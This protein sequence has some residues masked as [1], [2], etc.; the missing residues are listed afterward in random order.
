MTIKQVTFTPGMWHSPPVV[1]LDT[2]VAGETGG[3]TVTFSTSNPLPS[4]ANIII[5]MPP[6][7]TKIATPAAVTCAAVAGDFTA[8][9]DGYVITITRSNT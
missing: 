3:M 9:V 2:Y 5:E 7:F 1:T 8:A 4:D 6:T